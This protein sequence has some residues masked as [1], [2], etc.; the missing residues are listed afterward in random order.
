MSDVPYGHM[1][2]PTPKCCICGRHFFSFD[3]VTAMPYGALAHD[4][5]ADEYES[6]R[7]RVAEA[8]RRFHQAQQQ[9]AAFLRPLPGQGGAL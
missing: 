3:R 2:T 9:L 6:L 7:R 4:D 8:R 1:A 5:C